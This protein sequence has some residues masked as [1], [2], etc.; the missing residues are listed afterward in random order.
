MLTFC[1]RNSD[2]SRQFGLTFQ[3]NQCLFHWVLCN[4]EH[5]KVAVSPTKLNIIGP[6]IDVCFANGNYTHPARLAQ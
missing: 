5:G 6:K 1:I 4:S 2:H 3:I